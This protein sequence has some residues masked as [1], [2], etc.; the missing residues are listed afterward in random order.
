MFNLRELILRPKVDPLSAGTVPGTRSVNNRPLMIGVA[1]IVLFVAVVGVVMHNRDSQFSEAAKETPKQGNGAMKFAADMTAPWASS[2]MVPSA[3]TQPAPK[4]PDSP[5]S[6]PQVA[7]NNNAPLNLPI[8]ATLPAPA[9]RA[10]P[11][12]WDEARDRAR[13]SRSQ[14]FEAALKSRTGVQ[15]DLRRS[16]STPRSASEVQER[17]NATRQQLADMGDPAKVY[18][19]RLAAA[20]QNVGAQAGESGELA[21]TRTP[22]FIRSSWTLQNEVLPPAEYTLQAGFVIPAIMI[23]G[24]TSNLPGQVMAQVSQNVFDTPTGKHLLIPQGTRLVGT[25]NNEVA[26]GQERVLM[27]WQRLLFPDGRTLDIQAMPGA[28]NAGNAGFTDKVNNHYFR[29]FSSAILLS[30]VIAA[31]SMSQNSE[32]DSGNQQRASDALSESL[33]QTLG[34]TMAEM[35]RKNLNI[36]PTLQIRPG[37]RFNVMVTKDMV[38]EGAYGRQGELQ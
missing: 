16:T 38:F 33:G 21:P 29:T 13:L 5:A 23:S 36:A 35:I 10:V 19:A 9:P 8:P 7:E 12:P 4:I 24:I 30:G 17:L 37:Y 3:D 2:G 34:Q 20:G 25:Y 27:A 22:Q 31:V 26:Y 15:A 1:V 11:D 28:D 14:L 6:V 18:Q 32:E